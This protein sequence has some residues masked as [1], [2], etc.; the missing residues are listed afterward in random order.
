MWRSCQLRSLPKW[1]TPWKNYTYII[2]LF[3]PATDVI[4][5]KKILLWPKC[6]KALPKKSSLTKLLQQPQKFEPNFKGKRE[7]KKKKP[8]FLCWW[9]P[10][11]ADWELLVTRPQYSINCSLFHNSN[12]TLIRVTHSPKQFSVEPGMPKRCQ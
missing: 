3:G 12:I 7:A 4:T 9:F 2:I 11:P 6:L 5:S 10:Q 1:V 8:D